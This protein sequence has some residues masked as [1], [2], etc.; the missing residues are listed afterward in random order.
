MLV[1]NNKANNIIAE[2]ILHGGDYGG[3]YLSNYTH[4]IDAI[5]LWLKEMDIDD[6]YT[7]INSRLQVRNC[8]GPDIP[9]IKR[10]ENV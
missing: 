8:I 4:C 6:E 2:C 7:I 5:N 3:P 1:N 9:Q 10:K